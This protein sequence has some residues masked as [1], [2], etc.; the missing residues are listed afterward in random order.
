MVT[1]LVDGPTLGEW[2][3]AEKR[4]W[5]EVLEMVRRAGRGLAAALMLWLASSNN[6]TRELVPPISATR[7][8]GLT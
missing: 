4:P 3:D 7:R 8:L 2:L 1:E 5:R 6:A